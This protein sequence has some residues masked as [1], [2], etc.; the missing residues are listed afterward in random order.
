[1][2]CILLL[3]YILQTTVDGRTV[4]RS[5]IRGGGGMYFIYFVLLMRGCGRKNAK[6]ENAKT[7]CIR[8]RPCRRWKGEL[9]DDL[10]VVEI[11][12]NRQTD[13]QCPETVGNGGRLCWK[14]R[15]TTDCDAWG[16]EGAEE[17][18]TIVLSCFLECG[19]QSVTEL[20]TPD[21]Y[22]LLALSVL[23]SVFHPT[24]FCHSLNL[25]RR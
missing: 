10:S 9:E 2:N 13:R 6:P 22:E 23:H 17:C 18:M 16:E 12:K 5:Q 15:S 24:W 14:P 20:V 19:S 25:C 1:M 3:I 7:N 11:K 8:G 4:I 21:I